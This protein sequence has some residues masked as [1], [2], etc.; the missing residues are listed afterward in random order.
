MFCSKSIASVSVS[1]SS[2]AEA[3]SA[4]Q[5]VIKTLSIEFVESKLIGIFLAL[6]DVFQFVSRNI[7]SWPSKSVVKNI[8][9]I[10]KV[11]PVSNR[12]LYRFWF[13]PSLNLKVFI[14]KVLFQKR[15]I[16]A[17]DTEL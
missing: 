16:H 10:V 5:L 13:C 9:K 3:E 17:S 6:L 8:F 4:F 1:G 15:Y 2:S 7:R 14:W 11:C 12:A